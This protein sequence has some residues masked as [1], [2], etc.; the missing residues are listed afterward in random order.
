MHFMRSC[1]KRFD[2]ESL[3]MSFAER[4]LGLDRTCP[5]IDLVEGVNRI[6]NLHGTLQNDI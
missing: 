5:M 4:I 6:P 1:P 2:S 3:N